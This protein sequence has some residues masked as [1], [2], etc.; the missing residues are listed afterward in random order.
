MAA[1]DVDASA[2]DVDTDE[3][4]K[5]VTLRGTVPAAGQKAAAERIAREKAEGYTVRSQLKVARAPRAG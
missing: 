3:A 1:D 2:I 4:T 5:T